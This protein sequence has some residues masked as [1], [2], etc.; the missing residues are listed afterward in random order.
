MDIIGNVAI[1]S[2]KEMDKN[3][4]VEFVLNHYKNI[5][6][7]YFSSSKTSGRFRLKTHKL[8]WGEDNPVV[9][10]KENKLLFKLDINKVFFSPRLSFE[11]MRIASEIKKPENVL[12]LFAGVGPF[13]ITI[14]KY[15]V[16]KKI[17]GIELNK[18]AY[19]FFVENI[20]LNKCKNIQPIFGDV[21]KVLASKKFSNWAHRI[22]MPH[23]YGDNNY[24]KIALSSLKQ[25]GIIHYYDFA[26]I[27]NWK[28]N[29]LQNIQKQLPKNYSMRV[30]NSKIVRDIGPSL[31]NAVFDLKIKR[32]KK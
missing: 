2:N 12:V 19:K 18:A 5:R 26:K 8:I 28:E 17:I 3:K 24:L 4:A 23:P 20:K 31:V 9:I 11:R 32:I 22:L 6:S 27:K 25:N 10:H 7:I 21:K 15:S 30:L 29:I 14:S 16:A 13:P 1:F